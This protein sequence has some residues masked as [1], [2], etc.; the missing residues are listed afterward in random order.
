MRSKHRL[1]TSRAALLVATRSARRRRFSTSTTRQ[2]GGQGPYF[3]QI[4]FAGFLVRHQKLDQQL[5]VE[6]AIGVGH[7][8]PGD[9]INAGQ[10]SRG[11]SINIGK[12]RK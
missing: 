2:C 1:A 7:K 6:G 10:A 9:A 5:F 3:A 8:S 12:E 4:E 11:A